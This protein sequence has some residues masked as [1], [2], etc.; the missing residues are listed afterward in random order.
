MAIALRAGGK[1]YELGVSHSIAIWGPYANAMPRGQAPI[2]GLKTRGNPTGSCS[3]W[4]RIAHCSHSL[5]NYAV[6]VLWY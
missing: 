3:P 4:S 2:G 1:L 6:V 5:V